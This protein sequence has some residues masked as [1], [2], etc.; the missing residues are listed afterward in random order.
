MSV[1]SRIPLE[2]ER[3][4]V[5]RGRFR[6]DT[7]V[8]PPLSW[9]R[10]WR[11][12]NFKPTTDR[13]VPQ[14]WVINLEGVLLSTE[15]LHDLIVPFGT[16]IR[17]GQFGPSALFVATTSEPV[18]EMLASL[19]EK[20][21]FPL[22]LLETINT[23]LMEA[24]PVGPLSLADRT[25]LDYLTVSGGVGTSAQLA[26]AEGIELAAAG[27][28]LASAHD[29]SYVVKV[30]RPRRQGNQFIDLRVAFSPRHEGTFMSFPAEA[31]DPGDPSAVRELVDQMAKAQNRD[32]SEVYADLWRSYVA[33]H[34]DEESAEFRKVGEMLSGDDEHG[35][36]EFVRKPSRG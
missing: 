17:D 15:A 23:P 11:E 27:G 2:F 16:G 7:S 13:T 25:V 35:V 19:A 36:Q 32:P 6:P 8:Y 24:V 3:T 1:A 30:D 31:F 10:S 12:E 34:Y 4:L 29:K 5:Y 20:H 28:R 33:Q 14:S 21:Q 9:L 18:R 22:F 26:K